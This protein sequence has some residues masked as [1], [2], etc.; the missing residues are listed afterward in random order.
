MANKRQYTIGWVCALHTELTAARAF[1]TEEYVETIKR[2][3]NDANTYMFGS[4]GEHNV[5]IACLPNGQYGTNSAATVVTNLI[6][7]FPEVRF[8]L[9]VGIAGGAPNATNDVR[10][11]DVVVATPGLGHGGVL[12]YDFGKSIQGPNFVVTGHL[13]PPPPILGTAIQQLRVSHDFDPNNLDALV[14]EALARYPRLKSTY[15]QPELSEDVLYESD[16]IHQLPTERCDQACTRQVPREPR[17]EDED[18]FAVHYGLIASGNSLMKDAMLRDKY[19]AEKGVLCFEME[20]AGMMNVTGCAVIRGICDYSDT[21]KNKKWQGF[22]AM[23]AAAYA[24]SLLKKMQP[25]EVQGEEKLGEVI[26]HIRQGL[27]SIGQETNAIGKAVGDLQSKQLDD[28]IKSWLAAPG[29]SVNATSAR[30][31]RHPGTGE[32]FLASKQFLQWKQ[33]DRRHMWLHGMPGCGKTVLAT[34]I[35]DH[36]AALKDSITTWFFFDFS[37]RSLQ[38][39]DGMLRSLLSQLHEALSGLHDPNQDLAK[40]FKKQT[41]AP[42]S[43]ATF[44][45]CLKAMTNGPRKVYIVLDALDECSQRPLLLCW[46]ENLL[47]DKKLGQ[48]QLIATGR[49]EHEFRSRL[50]PLI[51]EDNCIELDK[52]AVDVDIRAYV[53][54]QIDNSSELSRW[55]GNH[56]VRQLIRE[57]IGNK[58]GGMFRWAACQLESLYPCIDRKQVE[59]VLRTLPKTLDETY[60]R[61]LSQIPQASKSST[62]RLLQFLIWGDG[63][64]VLSEA[65]DIVAMRPENSKT[66]FDADDRPPRPSEVVGYCPYFIT[67]TRFEKAVEHSAQKI[68]VEAIHLAHFSIKEYLLRTGGSFARVQ[69]KTS[70]KGCCKAYLECLRSTLVSSPTTAR[71]GDFPLGPYA[72]RN[73]LKGLPLLER[74]VYDPDGDGFQYPIHD[75][76][77]FFKVLDRIV[78]TEPTARRWRFFLL[79]QQAAGLVDGKT[80]LVSFLCREGLSEIAVLVLFTADPSLEVGRGMTMEGRLYLAT[81]RNSTA[82]VRI[83]L[84]NAPGFLC[85]LKQGRMKAKYSI[86]QLVQ[87]GCSVDMIQVHIQE[88]VM[89]E[90]E[91]NSA[92]FQAARQEHW[93]MF[94]LLLA[95]VPDANA[96]HVDHCRLLGLA[97][98]SG[99]SQM[100]E[101]LLKHGANANAVCVDNSTPLGLAAKLGHY[102]I[103][104]LLIGHGADLNAVSCDGFVPLAMAV[105]KS[106]KKMAQRLISAGAQ[107]NAPSENGFTPLGIAVDNA[108][109]EMIRMLV[110][111]GAGLEAQ[112]QPGRQQPFKDKLL[113][114]IISAAEREMSKNPAQFLEDLLRPWNNLSNANT[115]S[116]DHFLA[117]Q[118]VDRGARV[119]KGCEAMLDSVLLYASDRDTTRRTVELLLEQGANPNCSI[120]GETPLMC[121]ARC[122]NEEAV[123]LLLEHGAM[124]DQEYPR[125]GSALYF[126]I[127]WG[128]GGERKSY[129]HVEIIELLIAAGAKVDESAFP[130]VSSG[131]WSERLYRRVIAGLDF[132]RDSLDV[133]SFVSRQLVTFGNTFSQL[134]LEYGLPN[135]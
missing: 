96:G 75:Y 60:S 67:L 39:V 84:H 77:R 79:E 83:L 50:Q 59:E 118:L 72:A 62:I 54:F 24:S 92:L 73:W 36:V 3:R 80:S 20:A 43:A 51:G 29:P 26:E 135:P 88:G 128:F 40:L 25:E 63:P 93:D 121:V 131:M 22:A 64:L 87:S 57:E 58:A 47:S 97:V 133:G 70:I 120:A 126:A 104:E 65:V 45:T 12:Q 48:C 19:S 78:H 69:A 106:S 5:V 42:V 34:T 4:M 9:M 66:P 89:L 68:K 82:S 109:L 31:R 112:H 108:N 52:E 76:Y 15:S 1:L 94:E 127:F 38:T 56:T 134:Y 99:H 49:P 122:G 18:P 130:S 37:D 123:K 124:T 55:S 81:Q 61:I 117:C 113:G 103:M 85:S 105:D 86:A 95:N 23:T 114:L 71:P 35:L 7:S 129:A 11:G 33:G 125:H 110:Q 14:K 10:L 102:D 44:T 74:Q 16:C 41:T 119:E 132:S 90:E 28:S 53:D 98:K 21:H 91:H 30:D 32:W 27:D 46:M 116:S 111:N 8:V 101:W 115:V 100:V 17:G 2:K 13:S 6:R 107:I